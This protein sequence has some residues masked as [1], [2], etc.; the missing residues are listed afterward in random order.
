MPK[1]PIGTFDSESTSKGM[2]MLVISGKSDKPR[3]Q[4]VVKFTQLTK[5]AI[6]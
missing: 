1:I 5:N 2:T 3:V 6:N 4:G